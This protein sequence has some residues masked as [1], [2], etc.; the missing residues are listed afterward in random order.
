MLILFKITNSIHSLAFI[1]YLN[2]AYAIYPCILCIYRSIGMIFNPD[3]IRLTF[4][5]A[6]EFSMSQDGYVHNKTD[7][8]IIIAQATEGRYSIRCG[9]GS[10]ADLKTGEAF[11]TAPNIPLSI[12]HHCCRKTGKMSALWVHFNFILFDSVNLANFV[13]LPLRVEREW[14]DRFGKISQELIPLQKSD[15]FY[16]LIEAVRLDEIGF[17]L[18][19]ILLEFLEEKGVSVHFNPGIKRMLPALEFA[20]RNMANKIDAGDLAKRAGLSLPHFHVQFKKVFG[21]SPMD[22]VRQMRLIQA[23]NILLSGNSSLKEIAGLTGFCNQFHLSREFK[24]YYGKPPQVYRKTCGDI[25]GN[26]NIR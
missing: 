1:I 12:M 20:R 10:S 13:D 14:A 8:Y 21:S 17:R 23:C 2:I 4:L 26:T 7:P 11:L 22:Y 16:S 15:D 25:F 9:D 24:K 19:C 18:L 3:S 6:G 5:K